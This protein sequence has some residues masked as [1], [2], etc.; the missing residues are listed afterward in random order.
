MFHWDG[1]LDNPISRDETGAL[2]GSL[3]PAVGGYA[4]GQPEPPGGRHLGGSTE[5]PPRIHYGR[6]TDT[7]GYWA[8]VYNG[9]AANQWRFYGMS[10]VLTVQ[11]T[12]PPEAAFMLLVR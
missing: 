12:I 9:P 4:S 3:S 1:N 5:D 11:S 7:G 2:Q 10:D 6:S 8:R